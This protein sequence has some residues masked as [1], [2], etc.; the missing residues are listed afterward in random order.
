LWSGYTVN[1]RE[2]DK[3]LV[4][5]A[6]KAGA[7]LMLETELVDFEFKHPHVV[8]KAILRSK[9]GRVEIKPKVVIGADGSD[10]TT[11]K[12]LGEYH[13]KKGAT[14]E[15][16]AWEMHNMKLTSPKYEQVFVGDFTETG[17]AYVFPISRTK[18]NVGIGCAFPKKPMEEYFQEF[19]EIPEMKRQVRNAERVEDKGGKANAL[20]LCDKWHYGNVL[21]A[22]DAADQN[23]KPFVEGILPAVICGD[24]AGKTIVK[25]LKAKEPL[26]K[27]TH[28]VK[29]VLGPVLHQSNQVGTLIYDLFSMK[30][31]KEYLLLLNLLADLNT[32]EKIRHM[33]NQ[34]YEHIKDKTLEWQKPQKQIP[35]QINE[36]LYYQYL[37]AE[38]LLHK[39]LG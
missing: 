23:F 33:R 29:R 32:P 13:P 35:T 25:H 5:Q 22:G 24:I 34:T 26:E 28:E 3:W 8:E 21:L 18:A 39:L 19:L 11:L 37:K 31:P 38:R 17:Y 4:R 36:Y 16:Y 12:L 10:S 2:F 7:K 20:P 6:T 30:E 9:H 14:A 15:I 1:R 27:Y